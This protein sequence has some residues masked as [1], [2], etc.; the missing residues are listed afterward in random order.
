MN[1]QQ[2]AWWIILL[3]LAGA[4]VGTGLALARARRGADWFAIGT[5]AG[6]AILSAIIFAH[7][8]RHPADQLLAAAFPWIELGGF[9]AFFSI[10]IDSLTAVMLVTVTVVSLLVIVYSRGYM[11][12][13]EG[14]NRFFAQMSLFVASM[15]TL[16]LAG[17]FLMLYLGWEG[18]GL[19]SFMLIGFWY[20]RPAAAN[21][22]V[23]AF[24]VTRIGDTGFAIGILLIL[25]VFGVVDFLPVFDRAF[26]L[27]SDLATAISLLLLAGA[28]GK[29]A[30][31][32]LYVWL[33]DAMEGPTPV[34]AL[35]H[36]ATM[37]TAGVYMVARC[38]AIFVQS[39]IAMDVVAIIG[40]VTA[41][42]SATIAL[43]QFDIK[44]ILAYSTISQLGYMF[45]AIGVLTPAA[46]IF[47]LGTHAWFKALLFLASG[48]VMHAMD[49]VI[50]VREIGGLKRVL[51]VAY[52]VFLIAA[53]TLSGIFPFSG[54]WSKD[55]I[56]GYAWIRWPALGVLAWLTTLLTTLYIFRV[57][58]LVFHGPEKLPERLK[59]HPHTVDGWMNWPMI[60]L[61]VGSACLGII[62]AW[63]PEHGLIHRL[64]HP[65]LPWS[66]TVGENPMIYGVITTAANLLMIFL[67]WRIYT[68]ERA[69]RPIPRLSIRNLLNRKYYVDEIY[70]T[71][72][73]KPTRTAAEGCSEADNIVI[74][75][76]LAGIAW[77]PRGLA[78]LARTV[79]AGALQGYALGV[80]V[81]LAVMILVIIN[82]LG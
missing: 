21:A 63:P 17:N 75:G 60:I 37:V 81:L 53:L 50:D 65:S 20:T 5:V 72:V 80:A 56:V 28:V 24:V 8:L 39:P 67:A 64:L 34:S 77:I 27:S 29:S 41:I 26:T 22:A 31:I 16:V 44:R 59:G 48:A 76:I 79:Q 61:A 52:W 45:L 69:S 7:F 73:V 55:E 49:G 35:I 19:C 18:G 51:P 6:A 4:V 1:L 70:A 68:P 78:R 23:K 9:R 74:D 30:Q 2:L 10:Q 58:F 3:P 57:F 11:A 13:D 32:P 36:A 33:P 46:G 47:H 25:L 38:G 71:A 62:F 15:C 43:G 14:Y 82:M 12:Q 40:A 42:Y 66:A 54:F